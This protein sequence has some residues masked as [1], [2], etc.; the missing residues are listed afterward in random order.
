M[1]CRPADPTVANRNPGSSKVGRALRRVCGT[2]DTGRRRGPR[3]RSSAS[4]RRNVTRTKPDTHQAI[5]Q[6]RVANNVPMLPQRK[7]AYIGC[8]AQRKRPCVTSWC[9]AFCSATGDQLSPMSTCDAMKRK[10]QAT[11]MAEPR[12][13]SGHICNGCTARTPARTHRRLPAAN[14]KSRAEASTTYPSRRPHLPS[15]VDALPPHLYL[16]SQSFAAEF[17]A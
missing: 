4:I 8:L 15:Y 12:S 17:H 16:P 5:S 11:S 1:R 6:F 13:W 2:P 7:I 14:P 9:R 10:V 3:M